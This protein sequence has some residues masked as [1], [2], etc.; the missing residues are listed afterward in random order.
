[1][2]EQGAVAER[3][4]WRLFALA[5]AKFQG[6]RNWHEDLSD[7]YERRL[8]VFLELL[9]LD[10]PKVLDQHHSPDSAS[11][12]FEQGFHALSVKYDQILSPY[13]GVLYARE[14]LILQ[15]R[16][17][18]P[19]FKDLVEKHRDLLLDA[20]AETAEIL[21]GP[22]RRDITDADLVPYGVDSA[23]EPNEYAYM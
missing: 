12:L 20:M 11:L 19:M 15:I 2:T 8:Q 1:M 22:P 16:K 7:F 6:S 23:R 4:T 9:V 18:D 17:Y 13:D 21:W 5:Y 3:S 10:I 14:P